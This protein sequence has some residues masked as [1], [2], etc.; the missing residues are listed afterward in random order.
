[1]RTITLLAKPAL[2]FGANRNQRCLVD[3]QH[4]ALG[5]FDLE[6]LAD[7]PNTHILPGIRI[8]MR[9]HERTVPTH[10]V[11]FVGGLRNDVVFR[12]FFYTI[13]TAPTN[14]HAVIFQLMDTSGVPIIP[15]PRHDAFSGRWAPVVRCPRTACLT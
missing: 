12:D 5:V 3:V 13:L 14:S 15:A 7:C 11:G 4:L 1:A 6:V 8:T 9:S 10:E 2:S